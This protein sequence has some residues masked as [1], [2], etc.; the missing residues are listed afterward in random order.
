MAD[1]IFKKSPVAVTAGTR[2]RSI[3]LG[4]AL[5]I[6]ACLVILSVFVIYSITRTINIALGQV[7]SSAAPTLKF[8]LEAAEKL[9]KL[10]AGPPAIL[11]ESPKK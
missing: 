6:I 5:T 11:P 7:K 9:S 1:K 4:G 2:E 10:N 8:D 3:F